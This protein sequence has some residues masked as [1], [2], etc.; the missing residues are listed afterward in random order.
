M[1][2]TL[3]TSHFDGRIVVFPNWIGDGHWVIHRSRVANGAIFGAE[4][5]IRAAFPKIRDVRVSDDD[6]AIDTIH[7]GLADLKLFTDTHWTYEQNRKSLALLTHQH[8][9]VTIDRELLALVGKPDQVL[10]KD[11]ETAVTDA[12]AVDERTFLLMPFRADEHYL[13]PLVSLVHLM[14]LQAEPVALSA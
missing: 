5:T 8:Q 12:E 4:G 10:G 6:G 14:D 7:N 9:T 3:K 13:T 2:I 11:A 1:M